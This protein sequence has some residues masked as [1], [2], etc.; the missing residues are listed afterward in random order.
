MH[1]ACSAVRRCGSRSGRWRHA[2]AKAV[3]PCLQPAGRSSEV[4]RRRCCLAVPEADRHSCGRPA[5][6]GRCGAP[7]QATCPGRRPGRAGAHKRG[8]SPAAPRDQWLRLN[9]GLVRLSW[10]SHVLK[11]SSEQAILKTGI[12]VDL[13]PPGAAAVLR[14][15]FRTQDHEHCALRCSLGRLASC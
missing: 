15:Q 7:P 10:G 6:A 3:L 14:D 12:T 9:W 1:A 11:Y 8:R 5:R 4:F 13:S 2:L